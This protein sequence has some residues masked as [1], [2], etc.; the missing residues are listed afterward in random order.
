MKISLPPLNL[1]LPLLQPSLQCVLNLS[2]H[3]HNPPQPVPGKLLTPEEAQGPPPPLIPALMPWTPN[4][5]PLV[6]PQ[7][8]YLLQLKTSPVSKLLLLLQDSPLSVLRPTFPLK[9]T[10]L[11]EP[12]HML[13]S[14]HHP[15]AA[16]M[17]H[18]RP[19][20]KPNQMFL[21]SD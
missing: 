8:L 9:A 1:R 5:L 13:K 7:L 16:S 15:R 17:I 14:S 10:H 4:L 3:N 2:H 21:Q 11:M 19:Q 6:H 12:I 20:P 18:S